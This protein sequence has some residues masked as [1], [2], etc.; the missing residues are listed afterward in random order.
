MDLSKID[1]W[2]LIHILIGGLTYLVSV[3]FLE[4]LVQSTTDWIFRTIGIYGVLAYEEAQNAYYIIKLGTIYL[5]SGFFG[6]LYTGYKV[7]EKLKLIM[8][9]PGII[10]FLLVLTLQYFSGYLTLMILTPLSNL[11]KIIIIPTL[12]S[13]SGSYLGGYTMNWQVEEV[14]E[15]KISLLLEES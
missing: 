11:A 8:I 4:M 9:F 1:Y 10:G 2:K 12:I 14:T 6:G 5:S 3:L 15:E 13:L 7:K